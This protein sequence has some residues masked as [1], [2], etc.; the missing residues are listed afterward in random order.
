MSDFVPIPDYGKTMTPME[1]IKYASNFNH[2]FDN[3]EINSVATD[4]DK[5]IITG[6]LIHY[7]THLIKSK[8]GYYKSPF[9]IV[10]TNPF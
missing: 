2:S 6:T 3:I 4:K 5:H 8:N 9:K 7:A 10:I 1:Y